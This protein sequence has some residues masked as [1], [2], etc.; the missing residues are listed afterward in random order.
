M[1]SPPGGHEEQMEKRQAGTADDQNQSIPTPKTGIPQRRPQVAENTLSAA[2]ALPRGEQAASKI[3]S[4]EATAAK[5]A[6]SLTTTMEEGASIQAPRAVWLGRIAAV[7]EARGD[8]DGAVRVFGE[9]AATLTKG[10]MYGD[11]HEQASCPQNGFGFGIGVSPHGGNG[12]NLF[13][14]S[15]RAHH[16]ATIIERP[17]RRHF[18]RCGLF[19]FDQVDS[20]SILRSCAI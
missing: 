1:F 4:K 5:I 18:R 8:K 13:P 2:E 19:S 9:A 7:M 3:V 12:G 20:Q 17:Y 10:S 16:L 15:A 6:V 11:C 14:Y